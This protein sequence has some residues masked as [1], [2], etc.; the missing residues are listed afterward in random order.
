VG[1][2]DL[3]RPKPM[4]DVL[5]WGRNYDQFT[6]DI[7]YRLNGLPVGSYGPGVPQGRIS[8]RSMTPAQMWTSQPNFRSVVSF[9]GRNIAQLGLHTF[10]RVDEDRRRDRTSPVASLLRRPNP[11]MTT[12]ELVDATVIDRALYD[13]AYW[14]VLRD[15]DAPSGWA[16]WRLPPALSLIH[17]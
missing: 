14:A 10:E 4:P 5:P 7:D 2:L 12:Y 17:I 3:F 6:D 16:L 8:L 13:I 1:F 9:L 11:T 15:A